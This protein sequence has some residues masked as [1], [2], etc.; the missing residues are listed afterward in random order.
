MML[1]HGMQ[2]G[3]LAEAARLVRKNPPVLCMSGYSRDSTIH[4]GRL[5]G[6]FH[7]LQKPFTPNMLV[8]QVEETLAGRE[9]LAGRPPKGGARKET[10]CHDDVL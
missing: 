2:G 5:S 4:G 7:F 3:E 10:G 9:R 1:P 8:E 6:G